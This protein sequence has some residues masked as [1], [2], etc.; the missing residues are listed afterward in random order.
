MTDPH[1][2]E[3]ANTSFIVFIFIT[4]CIYTGGEIYFVLMEEY[5][6]SEITL[7]GETIILGF[8]K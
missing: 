1:S 2:S 7:F 6:E 8:N 5:P 3:V 4:P